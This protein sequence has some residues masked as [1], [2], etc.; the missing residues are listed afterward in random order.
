MSLINNSPLVVAGLALRHKALRELRQPGGWTEQPRFKKGQ[1]RPGTA[2]VWEF[3]TADALYMAVFEAQP[4]HLNRTRH[5]KE[6]G[7]TPAQIRKLAGTAWFGAA[8]DLWRMKVEHM[9]TS[10]LGVGTGG[11]ELLNTQYLGACSYTDEAEFYIEYRGDYLLDLIGEALTEAQLGGTAP[12]T[13]VQDA[14][15]TRWEAQQTEKTCT[16]PAPKQA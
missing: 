7:W 4:E 2:M 12:H 3:A 16:S 13:W 10:V 11:P 9:P 8:V 6:C 1:S 15:R 5:F 14:Q